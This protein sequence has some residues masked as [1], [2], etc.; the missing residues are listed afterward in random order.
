MCAHWS[1]AAGAEAVPESADSAAA[2]TAAA[3]AAAAAA[4]VTVAAAAAKP[5]E[6]W[7]WGEQRG[8]MGCHGQNGLSLQK[9]WGD[10]Q[11]RDQGF[12]QGQSHPTEILTMSWLIR[13]PER[14]ADLVPK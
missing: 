10:A 4:T 3:A 14:E 13:W 6:Q 7:R 5:E 9:V 11:G 12:Q 1:K 8:N 2:A